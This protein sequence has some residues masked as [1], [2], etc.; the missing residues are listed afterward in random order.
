MASRSS[1]PAPPMTP[2]RAITD[3]PASAPVPEVSIQNC[4]CRSA[5]RSINSTPFSPLSDTKPVRERKLRDDQLELGGLFYGQARRERQTR[6][7]LIWYR[8]QMSGG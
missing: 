3:V 8:A 4:H 5:R 7:V 6:R 2:S 1:P